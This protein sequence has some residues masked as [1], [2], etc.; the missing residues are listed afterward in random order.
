[1]QGLLWIN[2]RVLMIIQLKRRTSQ[3]QKYIVGFVWGLLIVI[4]IK[5]AFVGQKKKEWIFL[6]PW[7]WI[8]F[9]IVHSFFFYFRTT[10]KSSQPADSCTCTVLQC[11]SVHSHYRNHPREPAHL[12]E[13][14]KNW[15]KQW[16]FH[17]RIDGSVIHPLRDKWTVTPECSV[18][19]KFQRLVPKKN[20]SLQNLNYYFSTPFFSLNCCRISFRSGYLSVR[21]HTNAHTLTK[22]AFTLMRVLSY[23]GRGMVV[24][25]TVAP[26]SNSDMGRDRTS[27]ITWGIPTGTHTHNH[28]GSTQLLWPTAR[29]LEERDQQKTEPVSF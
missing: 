5:T 21:A 25:L 13:I 7:C 1:M 27:V 14:S 2:Q 4:K 12:T 18:C 9:S 11:I 16:R 15:W 17:R 8:L 3:I 29:N 28:S 20:Q 22:D 6:W 23:R 10:R 19:W 24:V 26:S